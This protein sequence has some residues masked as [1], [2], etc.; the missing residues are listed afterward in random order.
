MAYPG[1][2]DTENEKSEKRSNNIFSCE[3]LQFNRMLTIPSSRVRVS[4]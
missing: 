3:F 2:S 1:E 4:I